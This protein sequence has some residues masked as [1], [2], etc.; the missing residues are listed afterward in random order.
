MMANR[1]HVNPETGEAKP[2]T[3][4]I[5]CRFGDDTPHFDTKEQAREHAE[6]LLSQQHGNSIALKKKKV[7]K[8]EKTTQRKDTREYSDSRFQRVSDFSYDKEKNNVHIEYETHPAHVYEELYPEQVENDFGLYDPD[9]A[10]IYILSEEADKLNEPLSDETLDQLREVFL[11]SD[12]VAS[13]Y[14]VKDNSSTHG[15]ENTTFSFG[16]HPSEEHKLAEE[17]EKLR[18]EREEERREAEEEARRAAH[19]RELENAVSN[20][21]RQVSMEDI[22]TFHD[23]FKEYFDFDTDAKTNRVKVLFDADSYIEDTNRGFWNEELYYGEVGDYEGM[24]SWRQDDEGEWQIEFDDEKIEQEAQYAIENWE[25]GTAEYIH[26]TIADVGLKNV[27][28]YERANGVG[29][30]YRSAYGYSEDEAE[31]SEK[32]ERLLSD[33]NLDYEITFTGEYWNKEQEA[34]II[35]QWL[36]RDTHPETGDEEYRFEAA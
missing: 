35:K 9:F 4:E 12:T 33:P 19:L 6:R 34:E 10:A 16:Y 5:Q 1:Y 36:E 23:K 7:E 28:R 8:Y 13:T 26:S 15:D 31:V 25:N 20:D 11:K 18:E 30:Q 2:C 24:Y 21:G 17:I 32:Y 22:R 3:A 14:W 29:N 27:L